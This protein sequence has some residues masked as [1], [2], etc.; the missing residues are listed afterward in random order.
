ME[1]VAVAHDDLLKLGAEVEVLAP[2]ELRARL[3][4]SVRALAA[5]YLG[6]DQPA[7]VSQPW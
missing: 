1:Q 2:A 6:D 7:A 5:A 4:D 3:A